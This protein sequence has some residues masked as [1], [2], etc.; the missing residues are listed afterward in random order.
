MSASDR[1]RII[2][3]RDDRELV[4]RVSGRI[5]AEWPEFMLHDPV[6][7]NLPYCYD[8]LPEFQFILVDTAEDRPVAIANSIPLTWSDEPEKLPDDGWDWAL[9]TG[10]E[11]HRAGLRG[12]ILCALQVVVFGEYRGR[13]ISRTAV[14]VMRTIGRAH[15]LTSMIAP[16][17][18]SR[19][20]DFP[21][22]AIDEYITW[23]DDDDRLFD[24]WLRVH[25][26]L[27]ARIIKPCPSAMRITG[28][29]AEWEQWTGMQ[30]A[31]SGEHI[32]PG[33]LVP[34][35]ID[36][37]QDTGTYIEPNVWM[38]HPD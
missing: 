5:G 30:F 36:R 10:V 9:S 1:Y 29:V 14:D 19:K 34:V 2:T 15:G 24:P 13:G 17:R 31:D 16:V 27:G 11:Q 6:A 12:N 20:C 25:Y 33:A 35:V 4:G 3:A 22:T 7:D 32:V 21:M 37:E 38:Y 28:T 26:N 8:N 18:P 23:V